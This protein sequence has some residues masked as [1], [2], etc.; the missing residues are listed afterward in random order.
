MKKILSL[1][2]AGIMLL[3]SVNVFAVSEVESTEMTKNSSNRQN[4]LIIDWPE[5]YEVTI[6]C[7]P[8]A[9]NNAVFVPLKEFMVVTDYKMISEN[10]KSVKISNG[11]REIVITTHSKNAYVEGKQIVL[12]NEIYEENNLIYINIEDLEKLFSYEVSYDSKNNNVVLK[13]TENT[14]KAI[15]SDNL[16]AI[17]LKKY[18]IMNGDPDGNMR[19]EDTITRAEAV[20]LIVRL[21]KVYGDEVVL[22]SIKFD[23]LDGHWAYKEIQ[24]AKCAKLI[25]GTSETT[26]EPERNVTVQEFAKMVISLIGY[27]EMSEQQGGFPHGYIMTANSLGLFADI[28]T[29]TNDSALR[30]D[31]AIMLAIAL[32]IPVMRIKYEPDGWNYEHSGAYEI[33]DG[34][35]GMEYVTLR[36]KLEESVE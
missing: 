16:A 14:P 10:D 15:K 19:L 32:D 21:H 36:T 18:G 5:G 33:L 6:G 9:I 24:Y 4:V 25:D 34:Q 22:E 1:V 13:V 31:V 8:V 30:G 11:K 17:E 29:R 2:L 3:S 35:N 12:D 20:A 23:D 28:T 7:E 26:F 27:K